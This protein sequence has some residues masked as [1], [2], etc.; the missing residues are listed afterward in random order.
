MLI[1]RA[2]NTSR[3]VRPVS[4]AQARKMD[5]FACG[6]LGVPPLILMEN[7]AV[8]IRLQ[9]LSMLK[10]ES[11]PVC[12]FCGKGNN[13]GDGFAAARQLLSAG[14][15]VTVFMASRMDELRGDAAENLSVLRRIGGCSVFGAGEKGSGYM[16]RKARS[17]GLV[18]DALLGIGA[19]GSLSGDYAAMAGII[20]C[21]GVPV[22]S[23]DIPSGLNAD[24][25]E[26][27]GVCVKAAVTVTFPAPKRGMLRG[28][29]PSVCGK[30]V[31]R[32]LGVPLSALKREAG[33]R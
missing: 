20:N 22:L 27:M 30:I 13:G 1:R 14:K 29:G 31:V 17:S 19:A 28:R 24:S 9:A 2:R 3:G 11:R 16:L 5:L 8:G 21:A 26:I 7:A 4:S 23:V 32:D 18:I 10:K 6:E 15:Q 12:V 25:G 33:I